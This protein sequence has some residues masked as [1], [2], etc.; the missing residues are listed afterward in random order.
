V[1]IRKKEGLAAFTK[2]AKGGDASSAAAAGL[3]STSWLEL[4]DSGDYLNR[5]E[6]EQQR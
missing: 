2:V 3:P 5:R 4:Q 6:I 1:T